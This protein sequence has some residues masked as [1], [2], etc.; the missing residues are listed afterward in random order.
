MTVIWV[1]P[2][3]G[4]GGVR[5]WLGRVKRLSKR[6]KWYVG[7]RDWRLGKQEYEGSFFGS[8]S[9]VGNLGFI[10]VLNGMLFSVLLLWKKCYLPN[11]VDYHMDPSPSA[12]LSLASVRI[13]I[14]ALS[15]LV[16]IMEQMRCPAVKRGTPLCTQ[17]QKKN[18]LSK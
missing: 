11:R 16:P 1:C 3:L 4:P 15:N 10:L 2:L 5:W 18:K 13:Y 17:Q 9:S 8:T 14:G 7:D 6:V 12:S